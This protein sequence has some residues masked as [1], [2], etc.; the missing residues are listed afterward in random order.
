M[1]CLNY[2][3]QLDKANTLHRLKIYRWYIVYIRH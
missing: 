3:F 1:R 2:M